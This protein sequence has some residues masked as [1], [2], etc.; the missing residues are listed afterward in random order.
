MVIV[1][2]VKSFVFFKRFEGG[3]IWGPEDRLRSSINNNRQR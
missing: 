3:K 2:F 1:V